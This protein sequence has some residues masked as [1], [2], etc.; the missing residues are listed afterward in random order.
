MELSKLYVPPI[1]LSQLNL[2]F[3]VFVFVSKSI[4]TFHTVVT[5]TPSLHPHPPHPLLH[6]QLRLLPTFALHPLLRNLRL[7]PS[8][9]R[10]P[11]SL[12]SIKPPGPP[13]PNPRSATHLCH[14]RP[15]PILS[16]IRVLDSRLEQIPLNH[17]RNSRRRHR[18]T[19]F[20][21][22]RPEARPHGVDAGS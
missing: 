3:Q 2:G 17:N 22:P 20:R 12:I 5:P 19:Y 1:S 6:L 7:P 16:T 15:N 13:H 9:L 8:H 4:L 11:H 18:N 10:H 14:T 21:H